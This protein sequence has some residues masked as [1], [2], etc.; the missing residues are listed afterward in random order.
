MSLTSLLS[1]IM[2]KYASCPAITDQDGKRTV[3]YRELDTLS[4]RAAA[5]LKDLGICRGESVAVNL[6]RRME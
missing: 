4:A 1:D 6:D 5:K 3:S 2:K